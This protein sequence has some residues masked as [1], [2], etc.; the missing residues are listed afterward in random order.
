MSTWWR[1]S[2]AFR[3]ASSTFCRAEALPASKAARRA[4]MNHSVETTKSA[5]PRAMFDRRSRAATGAPQGVSK[6][7][8][9]ASTGPQN[10]DQVVPVEEPAH[11][12]GSIRHM[13]RST[14]RR[15]TRPGSS[16]PLAKVHFRSSSQARSGRRH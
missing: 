10:D 12:T 8:T 5:A 13:S 9:N 1:R 11:R 3:L 16:L 14:R 4:A 15:V 2:A 7:A 6:N